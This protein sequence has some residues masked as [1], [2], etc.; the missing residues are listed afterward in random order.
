MDVLGLPHF[1]FY[2][3]L[4][5]ELQGPCVPVNGNTCVHT[6]FLSTL[7][8]FLCKR[9]PLGRSSGL[10][11][12]AHWWCG[13]RSGGWVRERDLCGTDCELIK[14]RTPRAPDL[15]YTRRNTGSRLQGL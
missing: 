8:S 10:R 7:P 1:S 14:A 2:L 3:Q 12:P 11:V 9:P 13:L 4:P 15:L 6:Q 5:L